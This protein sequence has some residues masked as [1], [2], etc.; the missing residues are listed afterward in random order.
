VAQAV[1]PAGGEAAYTRAGSAREISKAR[2]TR[3]PR[4]ALPGQLDRDFPLAA[5]VVISAGS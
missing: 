1:G 3:A 2:L 5:R 4:I